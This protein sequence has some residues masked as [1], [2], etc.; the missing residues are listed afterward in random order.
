MTEIRQTYGRALG[1]SEL[2]GEPLL[3]KIADQKQ[4]LVAVAA[5][6]LLG[7]KLFLFYMDVILTGQIAQGIGIAAVLLLHHETHCGA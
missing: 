3:G 6:N 5:C 2:G 4:A 7:I 1:S